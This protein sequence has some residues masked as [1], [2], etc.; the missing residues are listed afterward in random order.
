MLFE[1]VQQGLTL[2]A[3]RFKVNFQF[4]PLDKSNNPRGQAVATPNVSAGAMAV[5]KFLFEG[6]ASDSSPALAMV[7]MY[8]SHGRLP[9]LSIGCQAWDDRTPRR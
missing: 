3:Y 2:F 5:V 4:W 9:E 7:L 6:I 1:I 8:S